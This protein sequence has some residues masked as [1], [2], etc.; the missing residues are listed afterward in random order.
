LIYGW[1][2]ICEVHRVKPWDRAEDIYGLASKSVMTF[3][4]ITNRVSADQAMRWG[5]PGMRNYHHTAMETFNDGT[6]DFGVRNTFTHVTIQSQVA[7][8]DGI[9]WDTHRN[10]KWY[11]IDYIMDPHG[12]TPL[13]GRSDLDDEEYGRIYVWHYL[14][15]TPP[16]THGFSYMYYTMEHPWYFHY[17]N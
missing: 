8:G 16:S 14:Y 3:N 12:L 15:T 11:H 10:L 17:R 5:I 13:F 4:N 7:L 6:I 1:D 2:E 9:W